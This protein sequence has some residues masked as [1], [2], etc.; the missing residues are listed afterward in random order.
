MGEHTPGPW[1]IQDAEGALINGHRHIIWPIAS[2]SVGVAIVILPDEDDRRGARKERL[3]TARLIATA[4][5]LLVIARLVAEEEHAES[6]DPGG[7]VWCSYQAMA[8]ALVARA[9]GQP[10]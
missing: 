5:D 8:Q 2:Q 10:A 6:H 9:T 3:A 7:C 1:A 4:P